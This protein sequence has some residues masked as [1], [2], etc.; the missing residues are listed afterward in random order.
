M[1]GMGMNKLFRVGYLRNIL[2]AS[3]FIG[4]M[5]PLCVVLIIYPAFREQVVKSAEDVS[6]RVARHLEGELDVHRELVARGDMPE[7][8][9][10]RIT[11]AVQNLELWKLRIHSSTGGVL[12]S[13]DAAEIGGSE[14][15]AY[16]M[17][18]AIRGKLFS[19]MIT[20]EGNPGAGRAGKRHLVETYIP[21]YLE[22]SFSGA[23]EIYYDISRGKRKLDRLLVVSAICILFFSV[24]FIGV[25]VSVLNRAGGQIE[26]R[27]RAEAELRKSDEKY[28]QLV[29]NAGSIIFRILPDGTITF[30]NDFAEKYFGYNDD[31][32]LGKNIIG[33][34][35]PDEKING[36]D[37]PVL[38]SDIASH[39]DKY[40][41][42]ENINILKSGER[43][44]ISWSN[45]AILDPDGNC[46]EILCVGNDI[47]RLKV[48]EEQLANH[49]DHLGE[50]VAERTAELMDA[51][52]KLSTTTATLGS[53]LSS[54]TEYAIAAI[55]KDYRLIHYN[56]AAE[57]IFGFDGKKVMGKAIHEIHQWKGTE[58]HRFDNAFAAVNRDGK[59]EFEAVMNNKRGGKA[60]LLTTMMPLRDKASRTTGYILFSKDIS[61]IREL[62]SDLRQ[63]R[64]MEAI[65]TLAGGIAH[66]FN[67]ILMAIMGYTDIALL[68]SGDN[69][70]LRDKLGQVQNAAERA[71]HLVT[72]ILTFSRQADQKR[73][74]IKIASIVGEAMMLIRASIPATIEIRQEIADKDIKILA[75]PIQVHQV[76]MNLCTNAFH[77]MKETGGAITVTLD[78]VSLEKEA[79]ESHRGLSPGDYARLEVLDT[80]KGMDPS[81]VD[82]IFEPYFT[83]KEHGEGTGLGLAMVHGIVRKHS[84]LI[85]VD[86]RMGEGTVFR[87]FFPVSEEAAEEKEAGDAITVQGGSESILLVDDEKILT[88]LGAEMLENLGYRVTPKTSS[89]EAL[90]AFKEAPEAFDLVVTDHTMPVMTGAELAENLLG[91]RPEIPIIL[92]TGFSEQITEKSARELGIQA[93]LMKP[94]VIQ[95]LAATIR[96]LLDD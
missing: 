83:T 30:L 55:D 68:H 41:N 78:R 29:H 94:L 71:G 14:V 10:G 47:T 8:L 2:A 17:D 64:K 31:E 1:S 80:G 77:A 21:I 62:E 93:F 43:V 35:V 25:I 38:I 88:E 90:R 46:V 66:D 37:L 65:G 7:E 92:C 73:S 50:L 57:K 24:I 63:S 39:P 86:S 76:L 9:E 6:T 89:I 13:T 22:N 81:I 28:R 74:V 91:L 23:F 49:R 4:V 32:L 67:N 59:Y 56:P 53:I 33:T 58:P 70:K 40:R 96:K 45:R 75:D 15:E 87:V 82:R 20:I 84:G 95:T 61:R 60:H 48:A 12:F 26:K 27:E 54:A 44:W 79:L 36:V 16:F 5:L 11:E 34:I 72:Q 69:Q 85:T 51:H 18:D 3:L 52:D 19:K 42:N